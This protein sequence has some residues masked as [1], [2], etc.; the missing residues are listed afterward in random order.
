MKHPI[1]PTTVTN[2]QMGGIAALIARSVGSQFFTTI[3]SQLT[4]LRLRSL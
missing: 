4:F 1:L 3:G 2:V